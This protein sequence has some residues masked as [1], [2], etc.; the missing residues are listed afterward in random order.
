MVEDWFTVEV[1]LEYPLM[2]RV[3]AHVSVELLVKVAEIV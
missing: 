1:A 2:Y 3:T